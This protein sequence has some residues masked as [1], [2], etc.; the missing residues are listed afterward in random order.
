MRGIL[1]IIC[2]SFIDLSTRSDPQCCIIAEDRIEAK[3]QKLGCQWWTW[4]LKPPNL[5]SLPWVASVPLGMRPHSQALALSLSNSQPYFPLL[6]ALFCPL[7]DMVCS[8]WPGKV[9]SRSS[10]LILTAWQPQGE[11]ASLPD[12]LCVYFREGLWPCLG[13]MPISGAITKVRD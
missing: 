13:H 8:T 2:L 1:H 10:R 12:C 11:S 3:L 4:A 9:T 6:S 7:A 5:R